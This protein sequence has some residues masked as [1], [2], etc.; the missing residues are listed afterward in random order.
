MQRICLIGAGPSGLCFLHNAAKAPDRLKVVCYERQNAFGGLWNYTWRSDNSDEHGNNVHGG[1]YRHMWVNTPKEVGAEFRDYTFERHFGWNVPS[2]LPR[3]PMRDYLEGRFGHLKNSIIFNHMVKSVEFDGNR[4]KFRVKAS[5]LTH[6]K[7]AETELFDCV[8]N[9][10]GH[11]SV[12]HVP[13]FEG[14]ETF[15]GRVTHIHNVRNWNFVRG[16]N[17]LIIGGSF[18]GDDAAL[19]GVKFGAEKV[20]LTVKSRSTGHIWPTNLPVEEYPALRRFSAEEIEFSDGKKERFDEV[21]LATGYKHHYP[22]L[23]R[24]LRLKGENLMFKENLYK[25]VLW[26]NNPKLLYLGAQKSFYTMTLFE[27]QAVWAVKYLSGRIGVPSEVE[28]RSE[29]DEWM[30]KQAAAVDGGYDE[31]IDF[32]TAY[33]KSLAE[34][35]DYGCDVDNSEAMRRWIQDKL[36]SIATFRDNG[37]FN[38]ITGKT[39]PRPKT[40]FMNKF[41]DS[42][43]YFLH[44]I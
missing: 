38:K 32:L 21:I 1:M 29:I 13:D 4:G 30:K 19:Q 24:D 2:F 9:A 34:A 5:E 11:F 23:Q 42:T 40:R 8:I 10:T 43:E 15:E 44:D 7:E 26:A 20:V 27:L 3:G 35:V 28:M 37:Y 39:S 36:T 33:V 22:H 16:K 14:V 25:G 18:S 12:P 41:N 31:A 6:D 17:V